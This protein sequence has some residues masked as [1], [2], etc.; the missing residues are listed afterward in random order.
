LL[1]LPNEPKDFGGAHLTL[2]AAY[3]VAYCYLASAPV[4]IFHACRCLFWTKNKEIGVINSLKRNWSIIIFPTIGGLIGWFGSKDYVVS[5]WKSAA[6][7]IFVAILTVQVVM[8]LRVFYKN[9]ISEFYKEL[10][11]E[12]N[13]DKHKQFV[14]SYRH[15]REHGNSFFIVFFEFILGLILFS[16]SNIG[17]TVATSPTPESTVRGLVIIIFTWAFPGL[18]AWFIGCRLEYD[19]LKHKD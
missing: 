2:L 16:Y 14:E 9:R 18:I 17:T 11:E 15:L 8:I 13:K 1:L 7:A 12:R 5:A 4:L 6:G 3:G 10:I 19:L